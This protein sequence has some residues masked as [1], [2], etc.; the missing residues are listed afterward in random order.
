MQ[1]A[2]NVYNSEAVGGGPVRKKYEKHLHAALKKQFEVWPSKFI[3]PCMLDVLGSFFV[4]DMLVHSFSRV[5][6]GARN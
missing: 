3:L 4:S 6:S 2:L 5:G 1:A